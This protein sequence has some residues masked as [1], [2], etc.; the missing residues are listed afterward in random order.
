MPTCQ[1]NDRKPAKSETK[2]PGDEIAFVIRPAMD[3]GPGHRLK[4]RTP[5]RRLVSEIKLSA[6]PAHKMSPVVNFRS[7]S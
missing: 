5:H 2:W 6:Y 3:H 1:I 7:N 4:V